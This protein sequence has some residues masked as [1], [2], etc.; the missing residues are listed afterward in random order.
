MISKE[1]LSECQN[2]LNEAK[3]RID[4][5][6]NEYFDG[7]LSIKKKE[8]QC[9][10][11]L[12]KYINSS[13]NSDDGLKFLLLA[14]NYDKI[15]IEETYKNGVFKPSTFSFQ[16]PQIIFEHLFSIYSLNFTSKTVLTYIDSL[17]SLIRFSLVIF[18]MRQELLNVISKDKESF[19]KGVL[20][21][22]EL[23]F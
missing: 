3:K 19:L 17:L 9:R 21:Y 12:E 14:L 20:A 16:Y 2:I 22:A 23:F 1:R 11:A 13:N 8:K 18:R 4:L 5:A 15:S 10:F 6:D 7:C